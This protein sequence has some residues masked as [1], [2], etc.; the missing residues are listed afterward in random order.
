MYIY[1]YILHGL[2]PYHL[3]Y[4]WWV[5]IVEA[6][7]FTFPGQAAADE[8]SFL[9]LAEERLEAVG[10]PPF[11]EGWGVHPATRNNLAFIVGMR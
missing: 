6:M 11:S 1:I 4:F 3:S 10:L 2:K 9:R 8:G 7:C 5:E